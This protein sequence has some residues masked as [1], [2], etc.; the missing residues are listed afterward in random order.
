MPPRLPQASSSDFPASLYPPTTLLPCYSGPQ[1]W[2]ATGCWAQ[3]LLAA[4]KA[5]GGLFEVS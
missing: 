4:A 5:T 1:L 2:A 3:G